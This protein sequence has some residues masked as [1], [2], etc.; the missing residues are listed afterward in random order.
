[1]IAAGVLCVVFWAIAYLGIIY[2]GFQDG[3]FGMPV[4][5]LAANLSW[6]SIYGFILDPLADHIH[7]LSIP[8]FFIDLVIAWQVFKYGAKD[9]AAPLVRKYFRLIVV[10][11]IAI[12]FPVVYLAFLE[13][14]DPLGEY[15]GF[16][17]N[18]MMSILFVAMF[19]R[20]DSIAGQSMYIA[21]GKWLGTLFAWIATALTVTTSQT[22]PVP[23]SLWSFLA[24]SV[25]HSEYPLTPLINLLYLVVFIVDIVYIGLLHQRIR[26]Q[27]LSPWRRF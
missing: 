17:I 25:T 27:G 23:E 15:T 10:V 11:A 19:L 8:C 20:R 9:F 26:Q 13:F 14:N 1:M 22:Q 21:V 5:A 16:G 24:G 3:S 18:F 2:R 6:E 7:I 4:A 12:A